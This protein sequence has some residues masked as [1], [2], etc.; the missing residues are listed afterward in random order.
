[1][2]LVTTVYVL[3]LG[4]GPFLWAPVSELWGRRTAYS[5]SMSLFVIFQIGCGLSKSLPALMIMRFF[6]G[7]AA[8]EMKKI[9]LSVH[10]VTLF[11]V[12]HVLKMLLHFL[13]ST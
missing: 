9:T 11:T 12:P 6:A 13:R 2:L 8:M 7:H 10:T 3:G 5:V 1:M 4:F